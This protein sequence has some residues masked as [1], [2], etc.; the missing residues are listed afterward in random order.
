MVVLRCSSV[1]S[2][3]SLGK[4]HTPSALSQSYAALLGGHGTGLWDGCASLG[5]ARWLQRQSEGSGSLCTA[6]LSTSAA[7][8]CQWDLAGETQAEDRT[9][10]HSHGETGLSFPLPQ[11][12]WEQCCWLGLASVLPWSTLDKSH[13]CFLPQSFVCKMD[14]NTSQRCCET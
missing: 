12:G 14:T 4:Q 11:T 6:F 3:E 7:R 2:P 10:S 9:I 5:T 8:Q 1:K 13:P